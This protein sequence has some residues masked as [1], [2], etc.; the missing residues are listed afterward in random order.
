LVAKINDMHQN[1]RVPPFWANSTVFE[2]EENM[3]KKYVVES[4]FD[5]LHGNADDAPDLELDL[6]DTDNPIIQAALSGEDDNWT[7]PE[8]DDEEDDQDEAS[9]DED[10]DEDLDD[11]DEDSDEDSDDDEDE[12]DD[13]SSEDDE[14]EDEDEDTKYSKKVQKR[15]DREREARR[16]DNEASERRIAKMEKKLELR[17]AR[18]E[19]A[20][21]EREANRKLA[22]LKAKKVEA[23]DEGTTTEVV[24][25]DEEILD[26]KAD[27]KAKQIALK[28]QEDSID[29]TPDPAAVNNTPA[30]GQKFL[31]KYP[32]FHTNKSF[33][34][35]VLLTDKSVA[36]RGLDKNS[37]E[38]Y[39]EMEKIL[40]PQFP[41]IVKRS[42]KVTV[43]NRR[44]KKRSAVGSTTKPGTR[45]STS[46]RT[47]RGVIRLTKQD[48]ANMQ[49][50]GMD[51]T[52]PAEAKA[53]AESKGK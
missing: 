48:Q 44:K 19:F 37:P 38:Y 42:T 20:K 50:F 27:I 23:L 28:Q 1:C 16:R 7:P 29:D 52:N 53:W 45:R 51:P 33:R 17:D 5:D 4:D 21:E 9:E 49:I 14:D 15:I 11:E 6:S 18:D 39:E 36:A 31:E 8:K 13:E 35:V 41:K 25:I 10:D 46:K 24:D 40:Q 43:K 2:P 12:D 32:Q 34:D 26:I 47:R 3:G 30:E 22:K